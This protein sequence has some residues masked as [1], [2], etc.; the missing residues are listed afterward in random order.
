MYLRENALLTRVLLLNR[1]VF[2]HSAVDHCHHIHLLKWLFLLA[3]HCQSANYW[4]GFDEL[5]TVHC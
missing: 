5:W 2:P 4:S 3:V 1:A